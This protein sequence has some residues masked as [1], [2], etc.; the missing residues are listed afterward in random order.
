MFAVFYLLLSSV[1]MFQNTQQNGPRI[2]V[3]VG[4]S[5][6]GAIAMP[7]NLITM[8]YETYAIFFFLAF[9][10]AIGFV[11]FH[12]YTTVPE[13][14]RTVRNIVL[15][16]IAILA[17]IAFSAAYSY[18]L[19]SSL[20]GQNPNLLTWLG[21]IG[22]LLGIFVLWTVV[23]LVS[24]FFANRGQNPLGGGTPAG[25]GQPPQN[26]DEEEIRNLMGEVVNT[27]N[28]L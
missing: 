23:L 13:E 11:V 17:Q 5:L 4:L 27:I 26:Q 6:I 9:M 3:A 1:P 12:V 2:A 8:I 19:K 10:G 24:G 28:N 25:G 22:G 21:L 14:H 16:A 20:V 7:G 15:F 18:L